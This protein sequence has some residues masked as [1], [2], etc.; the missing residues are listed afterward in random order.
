MNDRPAVSELAQEKEF[1]I[2]TTAEIRKCCAQLIQ[3]VVSVKG[4]SIPQTTN[5]KFNS[6]K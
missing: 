4:H 3:K 6:I 5:Q 2:Q 1:V